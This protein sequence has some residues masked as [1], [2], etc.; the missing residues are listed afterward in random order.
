MKKEKKPEGNQ[1]RKYSQEFKDDAIKLA[2]E[3][4]SINKASLRLGISGQTLG[5]WVKKA[6]SEKFSSKEEET[7][8]LREEVARLRKEVA[9]QKKINDILKKATAFFSQEKNK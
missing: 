3:L 7:K 2:E 4:G 5:N 8:A 1:K 9:E 6:R